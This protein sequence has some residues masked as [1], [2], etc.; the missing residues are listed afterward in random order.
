MDGCVGGCGG[1]PPFL[2]DLHVQILFSTSSFL[3]AAFFPLLL[4]LFHE[5]RKGLLCLPG[6][7]PVCLFDFCMAQEA[8]Y[9]LAEMMGEGDR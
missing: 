1:L 8:T 9:G 6:C 3:D 4:L 5:T 2:F 7:L